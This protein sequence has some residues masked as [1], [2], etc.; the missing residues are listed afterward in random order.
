MEQN[1]VRSLIEQRDVNCKRINEIADLCEREN[2]PRTEAETAEYNSLRQK[3]EVIDMRLRAFSPNDQR[4]DA[5]SSLA[6]AEAQLRENLRAGRQTE[7]VLQREALKTTNVQQGGMIPVHVQDVIK[8]LE[9]GLILDKVG[10]PLQTGLSGDFIWPTYEAVEATILGEGVA[11]TDST[12]KMSKL[13]AQPERIGVAIPITRQAVNQTDGLIEMIAKEVMPQA[14][15]RLLNKI[16]FSTTKVGTATS[17]VGPFVAQ[18]NSFVHLTTTPGFK[19]LNG[20]K[21]TV[22]SKGIDGE[23][24]CWVMTKAQK[25]I[26]EATPKDAGSGIMVCENDMICGL[27]VYTTS[28]IGEGFVGL[29]DWRYQPMGLFGDMSFIVDPYSQARKD[30]VDFVLNV[31][32]ATTTLRK[33]A[34]LLGKV[35]V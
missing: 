26:F 8:P 22:L 19:E 14:V 1:N 35:G 11:L 15:T 29:G 7:I 5:G 18:A 2:R 9:E 20:M 31:N 25:A 23:H 6:E 10:L 30:A 3:N 21:A 34:F 27:P 32:Y 28:Y 24:L 16:L 4:I 12:I 17:L 13:T 33:E